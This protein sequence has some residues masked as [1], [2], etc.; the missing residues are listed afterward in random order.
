MTVMEDGENVKAAEADALQ[1]SACVG[2]V[3]G[4]A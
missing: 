4:S 1:A 2:A 3:S